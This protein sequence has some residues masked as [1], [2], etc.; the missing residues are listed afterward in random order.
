[1]VISHMKSLGAVA[2][3]EYGGLHIKKRLVLTYL[4]LGDIC[5]KVTR[6]ELIMEAKLEKR[7]LYSGIIPPTLSKFKELLE[8]TGVLL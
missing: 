7:V 6:T 5:L 3:E 1:M 4:H 2:F 8:W